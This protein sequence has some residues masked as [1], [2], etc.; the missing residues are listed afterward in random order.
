MARKKAGA[1]IRARYQVLG[2]FGARTQSFWW[3][4]RDALAQRRLATQCCPENPSSQGQTANQ[5]KKQKP[6]MKRFTDN[7]LLALRG[8][9]FGWA[10]FT[11][12]TALHLFSLNSTYFP[13]S[14]SAQRATNSDAPATFYRLVAGLCTSFATMAI[15]GGPFCLWRLYLVRSLTVLSP[16]RLTWPKTQPYRPHQFINNSPSISL[17]PKYSPR[18]AANAPRN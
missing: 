14:P 15:G 17:W 9:R 10:I 6:P 12:R 3:C 5:A 11:A 18:G 1:A 16:L 13:A 2:G 7:R 4:L 8:V